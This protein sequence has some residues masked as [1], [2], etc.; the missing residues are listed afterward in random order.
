V[1]FTKCYGISNG[2][3]QIILKK[4]DCHGICIA[5]DQRGRHG[6]KPRKMTQDAR[7]KVTDFILSQKPVSRTIEGHRLKDLTLN[8]KYQ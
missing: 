8:H 4:I 3:V 7:K 2:K 6:N 5:A 1:A